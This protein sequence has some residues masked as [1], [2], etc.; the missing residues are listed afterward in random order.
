MTRYLGGSSPHPK[1]ICSIQ[2][3]PRKY[4]SLR[5]RGRNNE[6]THTQ[7]H[8]HARTHHR[9][10]TANLS[11]LSCSPRA[12]EVRPR[13]RISIFSLFGVSKG[14]GSNENCVLQGQ[15]LKVGEEGTV[16]GLGLGSRRS[17]EMTV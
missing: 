9:R 7:T 13:T 1:H 6:D 14:R 3:G 8:T 5:I 4:R 12:H 2:E 16:L 11:A 10:C 17:T 15:A